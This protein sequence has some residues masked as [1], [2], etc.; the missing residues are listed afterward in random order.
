MGN[1]S[2]QCFYISFVL[3]LNHDSELYVIIVICILG[4]TLL[5]AVEH[6][7][8][9]T[10][11][12]SGI[13]GEEVED[14][15]MDVDD[16]MPS[17]QPH[18]LPLPPPTQSFDVSS[19]FETNCDNLEDTL[20]AMPLPS[21]LPSLGQPETV[22]YELVDA[23]TKTGKRL[24]VDSQGYSYSVKVDKRYKG[25][26]V[27]WR[28]TSRGVKA[29]CKAVVVQDGACWIAGIH[30]HNHPT[31]PGRQ[32]QRKIAAEV[33]KKAKTDVFR[34]AAAI[35]EEVMT[36]Q[37][38][39]DALPESL[40]N[41]SHL[42]RAANRRRQGNRPADPSD[43]TF[44]LAMDHIPDNF[45]VS[46]I[47][48]DESRH[49]IFSTPEQ[50]EILKDA[51][52][53]YSDATF[54]V[55]KSPFTQLFSVHAF[56]K[57]ADEQVKQLP[58]A[59]ALMS[60]RRKRDYKKVLWTI[61]QSLPG[62]KLKTI[63]LDFE[64]ATW[65][66]VRSVFGEEVTIKGCCF[67]WRQAVWRKADS[68]GLRMPY[69]TLG[70]VNTF[71]RHLLALPYLP[72]EHILLSFEEIAD[73]TTLAAPAVQDLVAY[74]RE[75]WIQNSMW[76][77]ES[78]SVFNRSVRTNNDTEGWHRRLNTRGRANQHMYMLINNLYSE[79][80]LV[81][82]QVQL[83][84]ERKLKR[85][86][87]KAFKNMQGRLFDLWDRYTRNEIKTSQL[88]SACSHLSAPHVD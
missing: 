8:E 73:N 68:L 87:R 19:P 84:R 79:A 64:A 88:L 22:T 53:W 62:I 54:R 60:R 1:L 21:E 13:G 48:D 14:E 66:A 57:G 11:L 40:P 27:T 45:L 23:G 29:P 65:R 46:D 72:A 86:Q 9:S 51:K 55:V 38:S 67:H 33:K 80:K 69:M 10:R 82:V 81:P 3:F 30:S 85:H 58:L 56:V 43:I 5:S 28:C 7:A 47:Q 18:S 20:P 63:V 41:P 74:I 44:E 32:Q 34:P 17:P 15:E 26:K 61:K 83:V 75:T 24:L 76:P 39:E 12:S 35:V 25:T 36:R 16:P 37:L 52:T 70:P 49:L 2:R 42:A 71:I 6:N 31:Q 59:F 50:R 78:W 4:S 77:P